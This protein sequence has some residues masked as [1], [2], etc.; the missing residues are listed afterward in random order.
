MRPASSRDHRAV[1]RVS[2]PVLQLSLN[3]DSL[4][5]SNC[6]TRHLPRSAAIGSGSRR[7]PATAG[8]RQISPDHGDIDPDK[9]LSRGLT[10][11]DIVNAGQ[12][13][14]PDAAVGNGEI[15]RHQYTG[16]NQREHRRRSDRPQHEPVKFANGATSF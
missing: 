10:P 6:T 3:S 14:E 9:L 2:V 16:A 8:G 1:Q 7:H 12:Y 15:R 11:L 5:S 13:A 4:T